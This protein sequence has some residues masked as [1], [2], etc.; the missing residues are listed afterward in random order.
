ME[1][2]KKELSVTYTFKAGI[3]TLSLKDESVEPKVFNLNELSDDVKDGLMKLGFKTKTR[4][5][6]CGEKLYGIDKFNSTVES[7]EQL[8]DGNY[9]IKSESQRMSTE[10][11]FSEWEDFTDA[12]KSAIQKINPALFRKMSKLEE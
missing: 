9:N 8:E 5:H 6:R 7:A 2:T 11:Q 1:T 4:N 10:D 12:E 3:V